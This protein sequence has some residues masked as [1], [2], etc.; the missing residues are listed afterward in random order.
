MTFDP[1]FKVKQG[2]S[3]LKRL[4]LPCNSFL[5][6]RELRRIRHYLSVDGAILVANALVSSHLDY[7]NSLFRSLTSINLHRLQCIQN[8]LARIVTNQRRFSRTS[9]ILKELHW[10]P[11][12]YR[13]I[14]K[15][16]TFVYKFPSS[17]TPGYFSHTLLPY[18]CKYNTRRGSIQKM[19][20]EVPQFCP[21]VHKSK[22]QF[23]N[24]CTC[25]LEC[26]SS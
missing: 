19:F 20:L 11:V 22:K 24:R 23:N 7:F 1:F 14:F 8:T 15:V 10:L 4:K 21:P 26:P 5:H 17:G 3:I 16:A 25:Y 18:S 13:C 2:S 9:P 12:K 6:L